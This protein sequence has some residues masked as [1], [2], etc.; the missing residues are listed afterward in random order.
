MCILNCG[1]ATIHKSLPTPATAAST[2]PADVN[3]AS[4]T[5]LS[6]KPS[7]IPPN[8]GKSAIPAEVPK[9]VEAVPVKMEVSENVTLFNNASD[10]NVGVPIVKAPIQVYSQ[11][12][13]TARG[14]TP[15]IIEYFK[16]LYD[17]N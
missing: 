15:E 6:F 1:V 10:L 13:S 17:I 5:G 12:H 16:K 11:K 2:P 7:F 4:A 9:K 3:P 8:L 14:S